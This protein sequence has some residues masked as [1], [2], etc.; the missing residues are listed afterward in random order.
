[1][2]NGKYTF[3]VPL[4]FIFKTTTSNI[5]QFI[6]DCGEGDFFYKSSV[7]LDLILKYGITKLNST[8]EE[9]LQ[10]GAM[11]KEEFTEFLHKRVEHEKR[12]STGKYY[13]DDYDTINTRDSLYNEKN[14]TVPKD[15]EEWIKWVIK[16]DEGPFDYGI[17]YFDK[18]SRFLVSKLR[19]FDERTKILTDIW[20]SQCNVKKREL[21][22]FNSLIE[23]IR[24]NNAK[25]ILV[26]IS[27]PLVGSWLIKQIGESQ[28]G[29][30]FSKMKINQQIIFS[31]S[32]EHG[33][34]YL[35]K[36]FLKAVNY[37]IRDNTVSMLDQY[38]I[39]GEKYCN[40]SYYNYPKQSIG[41]YMEDVIDKIE[42]RTNNN[43]PSYYGA[44]PPKRFG[45]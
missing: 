41:Q 24:E 26:G 17:D 40:Y 23:F 31:F 20:K 45:I 29:E 4:D 11:P 12:V 7:T 33:S 37:E 15:E 22:N 32:Y 10:T 14:K 3:I 16:I 19:D 18:N 43:Q 9:E 1:M 38:T 34:L 42:K 5:D 28:Y 35:P 30:E 8:I 21:E 27:D 39:N 36:L 13:P 44:L 6:T 25:V 2:E